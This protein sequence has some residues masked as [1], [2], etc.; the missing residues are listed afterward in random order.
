MT[1]AYTLL[2]TRVA[3]GQIQREDTLVKQEEVDCIVHNWKERRPGQTGHTTWVAR[4]VLS[5]CACTSHD[6]ACQLRHPSAEKEGDLSD[7]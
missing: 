3:C 1:D 4:Y 5:E 2:P 7:I 6:F